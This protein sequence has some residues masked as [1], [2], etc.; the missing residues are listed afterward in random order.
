MDILLTLTSV[1]ADQGALFD[2]YSNVDGFTTPFETDVALAAL[3][4]G[5]TTTLAPSSTSTVRICG[6]EAACPNCVDV[7]PYYTTTTSTTLPPVECNE[8]TNSGG[9]GV[10]EYAIPLDTGGGILVIDFNAYNIPDKLEILHNGIKVATS[11]MT[12]ANSGPFDDL[13]G[14]P[15]VPDGSQVLAVDQFIGTQKNIPPSREA[16]I[17]ADT[18]KVFNSSLQQLIW[19]EYTDDDRFE[20]PNAIIRITGPD[21]TAWQMNRLCEEGTTTTTTTS[22]SSTTTT[23]STSFT[24][25]TTTTA[26]PTTT[27]TTTLAGLVESGI[28]TSNSLVDGCGLSVDD[29]VYIDRQ[30]PTQLS[31]GDFVFEDLGGTEIFIGNGNY[32]AIEDIGANLL[33]SARINLAG[34]ILSPISICGPL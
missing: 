9:V 11:G 21:G 4:S 32:Y 8:L 17:F 23:T 27:T 19:W 22:S 31:V 20:D 1:G 16:E 3:Q 14:D 13:Y 12:V 15:T 7:V 5:Y 29:V 10:T 30:N 28:S 2:L 25:T 24:T 34:Q 33:V 18:G 26:A 6:Q